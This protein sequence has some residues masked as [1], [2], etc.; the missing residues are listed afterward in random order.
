M[1][2]SW[3]NM[4]IDLPDLEQYGKVTDYYAS[5]EW[6]A[7]GLVHAH[8]ALWIVGSPRIDKVETPLEAETAGPVSDSLRRHPAYRCSAPT[9][10]RGCEFVGCFLGPSVHRVQCS[11]AFGTYGFACSAGRANNTW[12]EKGTRCEGTGKFVFKNIGSLS[13]GHFGC[14]NS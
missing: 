10:G 4:D 1:G 9:T 2:R 6:S 3:E 5:L 8:I 14:T 11:E 13:R 12:E 7:G